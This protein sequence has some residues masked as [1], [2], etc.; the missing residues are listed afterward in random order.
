MFVLNLFFISLEFLSLDEEI[1]LNDKIYD[2]DD[3]TF[4][5]VK[6]FLTEF[7]PTTETKTFEFKK[8]AIDS[9]VF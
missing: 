6:L 3:M 1:K 4:D 2:L 7:S 9:F 5:N 8:A